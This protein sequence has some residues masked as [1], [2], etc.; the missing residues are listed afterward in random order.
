MIAVILAAGQGTRMRSGQAKVLHRVAGRPLVEH[1][2]RACAEAG[3]ERQIVVI[4]HDRE[5]VREALRGRPVEFVVQEEQRGTG[6]AAMMAEPLLR[7]VNGEVLV[8]CGDV[9]L[10]RPETLRSLGEA[11]RREG[12]AATVLTA[13]FDEPSGYGRIVKG[14]QGELLRIVEHR[15]AAPDEQTIREVNSG[16]YCF[17]IPAMFEALKEITPEN[18]QRE[19]Y[20]TDVIALLR[21]RGMR[22][23][24][25]A[26]GDPEEVSGVN[27]PQDLAH[28]EALYFRRRCSH[29][30][31]GAASDGA[32]ARVLRRGRHVYLA[33]AE[34]P[35]NSGHCL[36][37]PYRHVRTLEE[38]GIEA[39]AE[40]LDLAGRAERAMAH[41]F[42]PEGYNMG[43]NT[44]AVEGEEAYTHLVWHVIPRWCG[45]TNFMASI[46]GTK[47]LPESIE[48]TYERL[49]DALAHADA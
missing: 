24:A 1:V 19:F 40:M 14:P 3:A 36:V 8:L 15:D 9:P 21:S 5:A 16:T 11:H 49:R 2:V 23:G 31:R 35:F 28:A 43:T 37:V 48:R 45:D 44:G 42:R 20:L 13:F 33:L 25:H 10:I 17:S 7:G 32:G 6:H 34:E 29:C 27:T 47:V 4:G 39:A 38:L 18:S 12:N 26:A 22:V 41:A 46:G 30:R